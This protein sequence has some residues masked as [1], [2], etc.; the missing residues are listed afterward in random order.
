[1]CRKWKLKAAISWELAEMASAVPRGRQLVLL[2]LKRALALGLA[3]NAARLEFNI[4]FLRDLIVV[5]YKIT[6]KNN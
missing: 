6:H 2:P 3:W 4:C 1:V 5:R